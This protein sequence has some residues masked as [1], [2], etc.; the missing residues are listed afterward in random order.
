MT[1]ILPFLKH[2]AKVLNVGDPCP[3][4]SLNDKDGNVLRKGRHSFQ[5][6]PKPACRFCGKPKS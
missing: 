4:N 2:V 3:A 6:Y 1:R 5:G